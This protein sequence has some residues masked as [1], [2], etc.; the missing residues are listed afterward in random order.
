MRDAITDICKKIGGLGFVDTMKITGT[1]DE[2]KVEAIDDKKTVIIKAKLT[3]PQI[4]LAGTFGISNLS[5]LSGLL[6]FSSYKTDDA[7]FTVKRRNDG[8]C[9]EEFQFRDVNGMGADFR[10]MAG[11]LVADQPMVAEIKWDV[12]FT[13]SKSKLQEFQ[14]LAGLYSQFDEFFGVKTKDGALVVTIGEEDSAT[15]RAS[16]V[17]VDSVDGELKG[18]LLWP[19]QQFLSIVK[20]GDGH[21]YS[22]SITSKGALQVKVATD[23][24]EYLF[25]LPARRR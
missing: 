25:I 4:D 21:D 11:S 20:M 23:F 15:H 8:S 2:T 6:N 24:A 17:L 12:T 10:L 18:E 3:Q 13:P 9:P 5:L 7:K 22:V 14:A 1:A 19:I 16:M